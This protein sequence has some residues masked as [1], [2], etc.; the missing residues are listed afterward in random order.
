[1][2]E[3]TL[4]TSIVDA[5]A[6]WCHVS[7]IENGAGVGT[8][9]LFICYKGRNIWIELKAFDRPPKTLGTKNPASWKRE[10][11]W[12]KSLVD[13][14]GAGFVCV[15][16]GDTLYTYKFMDG[17]CVI[18]DYQEVMPHHTTSIK[19]LNKYNAKDWLDFLVV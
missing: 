5:I 7:K 8:P 13:N 1:M 10:C 16:I 4:K 3:A 15:V 19:K 2:K 9:D 11:L 17:S 18:D 14:G 12:L 6:P